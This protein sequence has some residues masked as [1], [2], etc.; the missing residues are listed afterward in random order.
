MAALRG[1]AYLALLVRRQ[2]QKWLRPTR[3]NKKM[4]CGQCDRSKGGCGSRDRNNIMDSGPC[5]RTKRWP[6][7]HVTDPKVAV[8]HVIEWFSVMKFPVG[9]RAHKASRNEIQPLES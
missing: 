2:I 7:A 4:A 3:Q 9:V 1:F 8:A 5:D 6:V